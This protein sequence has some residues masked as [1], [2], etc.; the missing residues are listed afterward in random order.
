MRYLLLKFTSVVICVSIFFCVSCQFA[1]STAST[2]ADSTALNKPD[3]ESLPVVQAQPVRTGTFLLASAA[4]GLIRSA[5]QSK[6]HFRSGGTISRIFVRNGMTVQAGQ[7]LAQLDK[8]DQQLAVRQAEDQVR[9]SVAQLRGLIAEYGGHDLDT[10]SLKPNARAFVLTKSGYYRAHTALALARQNLGYTDLR[11]PYAGTIANLSAQPYNFITAYEVFCTLLSTAGLQAEFS[12][13][14]SELRAIREGQPVTV[15]PVARPE[16]SYQGQ[17]TE[18]NPFVN[19]QGLVL[20]RAGIRQADR[21]LFE[22]M[23]VRVRVERRVPGQLIIPKTAVVERS[24]RKVVF[25]LAEEGGQRLAKWNYVTIAYENDTEVA[26]SEG[27]KAGDQVIISGNLNLA[28][29]AKVK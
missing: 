25:T 26:V 27:L 3:A 2:E 10:N 6:L 19:G 16:R 14:E 17:V 13:L 12:V 21:Q 1:A 4:T 8:Q 5:A 7:L 29:D 20:V 28:H 18:I 15:V 24:G 11:A 9:E 23:N 22:G